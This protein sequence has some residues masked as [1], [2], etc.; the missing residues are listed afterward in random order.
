[1]RKKLKS[2]DPHLQ[3]RNQ[4]FERLEGLVDAVFGIAITLSIFN[5]SQT[6]SLEALYKFAYTLPAFIMCIGI[7]FLFWKGH[8]EFSRLVGFGDFWLQFLNLIFIAL[9]I[10]FVFPLRF[11]TLMLTQL[12]FGVDMQVEMTADQMPKLMIYY[13]FVAFAVYFIM[14]LL[15]TRAHKIDNQPAYNPS[16]LVH[17]KNQQIHSAIMFSVPL[18]SVLCAWLLQHNTGLASMVSGFVYFL[19][20]PLNIWFVKKFKGTKTKTRTK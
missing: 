8:V 11:L 16:E 3:T 1:M 2:S 4:G 15:Y 10:F 9:I 19:Y 7:L 17:L 18:L 12:I 5:L 20:I 6:V 13:G 14:F